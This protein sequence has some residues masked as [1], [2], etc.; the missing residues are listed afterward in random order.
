MLFTKD[1]VVA[2][3]TKE[4]DPIIDTLKIARGI[5]TWVSVL[6]PSGCNGMV[7]CVIRHHE[8]QIFPS[9]EK[10]FIS[11]NRTP[12]E[13]SDYYECYQPPYEL[14]IEAWSP[15]TTS[16]HTITIK[17]AVLPRKATMVASIEDAIRDIVGSIV[18][19]SVPVEEG[20][21]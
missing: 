17:M 9:T 19:K 2:K 6:F 21:E 8:H 13:W 18:P 14:K 11:G 1:I 20:A 7:K 12:I 16:D 3:D 5:I 15:D 10:M 4:N